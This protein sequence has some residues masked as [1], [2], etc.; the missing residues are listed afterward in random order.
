MACGTNRVTGEQIT[1]IPSG[2]KKPRARPAPTSRQAVTGIVAVL[3][4]VGC[5][6]RAYLKYSGREA[7]EQSET[8]AFAISSARHSHDYAASVAQLEMVLR[9]CPKA[10]NRATAESTLDWVRGEAEQVAARTEAMTAEMARAQTEPDRAEAVRILDAALENYPGA[11]NEQA[12]FQLR[13]RIQNS[14]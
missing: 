4:I 5:A 1:G 10:R 6:V 2:G 9:N 13:E 7:A 12:A 3:V 8:V 14:P 11:Q